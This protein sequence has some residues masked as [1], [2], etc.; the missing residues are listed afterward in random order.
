M[1]DTKFDLNQL[2]LDLDYQLKSPP[3]V[4]PGNSDAPEYQNPG[5]SPYA[6]PAPPAYQNKPQGYQHAPV[7]YQNHPPAYPNAQQGY[8][9][10]PQGYPVQPPPMHPDDPRH[11]LNPLNMLDPLNPE[12]FLTP[13]DPREIKQVRHKA[14][15]PLYI[16]FA[17]VNAVLA[18][19]VLF[20]G[21]NFTFY[22]ES[23]NNESLIILMF[24]APFFLVGSLSA[25]YA[26]TRAYAI[27]VSEYNF[28]E[29]Y[30]KSVEYAKKL[31]LKK[32]PAVYV[33]QQNGILNAFA[34]AVFGKKRYIGLNAELVDIAY[35]EHKDFDPIYFI[36][37][38]EFAHVYFRHVT[39]SYNLS[40][41][42]TGLLPFIN[43]TLSRAR[44]YSCDRVAQLLL[45]RDG[46]SEMI[47]LA[48]GRHLYKYVDLWDYLANAARERGF[49]LWFINFS[50][51][52][53][54]TTKRITALADPQRKSGKLFW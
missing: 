20:F 45:G 35:M 34:A 30:Y 18:V 1:Q 3:P 53:P 43:S 24:I 26:R 22:D 25:L 9:G 46:V 41:F 36:L 50:S 48:V 33:E 42:I 52:H 15:L 44:E 49:Y 10:Y 11:P 38:H 8:F 40:L 19:C 31:G 51:T 39:F 7:D 2:D 32:V 16:I 13:L 17:V 21:L 14:E 29:I 5:Y 47:V 37:A 12:R 27:R 23:L 54:I 6:P 4:S 28:P